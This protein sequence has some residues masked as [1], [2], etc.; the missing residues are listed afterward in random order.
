VVDVLPLRCPGADLATD[1][2]DL[3][4]AA[5]KYVAAPG[6]WEVEKGAI[7]WFANGRI[8]AWL[9]PDLL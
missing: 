5:A 2:A 1:L 8:R 9:S 7:V 3:G 6:E 4:R